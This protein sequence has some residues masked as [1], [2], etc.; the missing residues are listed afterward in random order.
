MSLDPE[1]LSDL[2]KYHTC[3]LIQQPQPLSIAITNALQAHNFPRRTATEACDIKAAA[4]S[5]CHIPPRFARRTPRRHA[6]DAARPPDQPQAAILV[7]DDATG[8]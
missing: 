4:L 6:L 2:F 5:L 7:D 3:K 1:Y 8:P